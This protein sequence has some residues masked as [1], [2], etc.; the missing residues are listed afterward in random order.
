MPPFIALFVW[1][2]LLLALLCFD[3]AKIRATS[4]ALWVPVIWM[5]FAGSRLPSQWLGALTGGSWMAA[6]LQDGNPLDRSIDLVLIGLAIAIL[7]TRSFDW[8]SFFTRNLAVTAFII[9]AMLSVFWS[10]FPLV[11]FKRWFRDLGNYIMILVVLSDP[12]PLD[13]VRT[14]FRR[15]GYLLVPLS[16]LLDKYFPQM[17]KMYDPWS[18]AGMYVGVTTGKNL[19]GLVALLSGVFFFWDTVVRWP[20]KN[21]R[22][23][24]RA[25]LVNVVFLAMSFRLLINANSATCKVCMVIGCLIV[26]AIQSKWGKRHPGFLKMLI[27]GSFC[28]YLIL[29]FVFGMSGNLAAAIGKDPTLTDRTKIWA[30]VLGMHTNPWIGTGYESFWL[31]PRLQWIWQTSGLGT[32]NE[33][34]NG[35]LEVYLNLGIIGL[36]LIAGI[37]IASY[38]TI[39]K[40]FAPFSSLASLSLAVWAIVLFFNVTEAGFRSG[41]LWFAFLLVAI[42]V[43]ARDRVPAT[44]AAGHVNAGDQ[45]RRQVPSVGKSP[46]AEPSSVSQP[47]PGFATARQ[48]ILSRNRR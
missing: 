22:R 17:S 5:F 13:A 6:N 3:P 10:D 36:L 35:Y 48:R 1:F 7:V 24:K 9:F 45:F 4:V 47:L 21:E 34:H 26:A 29:T 32:I 18:G 40:R 30:F 14:V 20:D 31:G 15:L 25:I 33:A 41:L 19:L 2:V 39:C 16:I 46:G 8:G 12:L 11:A 27:P 42:S 43:K 23:A 44:V 37:L 28:L 38:R